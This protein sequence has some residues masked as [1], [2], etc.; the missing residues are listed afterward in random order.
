MGYLSCKAFAGCERLRPLFI[1]ISLPILVLFWTV[2]IGLVPTNNNV[3]PHCASLYG[4]S[5][6]L[7]VLDIL[8]IF[9]YYAVLISTEI[10]KRKLPSVVDHFRLTEEQTEDDSNNSNV[11][12]LTDLDAK[13]NNRKSFL[14]QHLIFSES[15]DSLN[16]TNYPSIYTHQLTLTRSCAFHC[17]CTTLIAICNIIMLI[18]FALH[19]FYWTHTTPQI[20]G[21]MNMPGLIDPDGVKVYRESN[22]CSNNF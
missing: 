5:V 17:V 14:K 8:T 18:F 12:Q 2:F 4:L 22:V 10:V 13:E 6:A 7:I 1:S 11:V 20:S 9:A 3:I 16:T 15:Q 19:I 21:V